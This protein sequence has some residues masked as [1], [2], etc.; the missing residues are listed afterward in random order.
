M[1]HVSFRLPEYLYYGIKDFGE[2]KGMALSESV[3]FIVSEYL[4]N[5]QDSDN[6]IFGIK[7]LEKKID[8]LKSNSSSDLDKEVKDSKIISDLARIK[9]ALVILGSDSSRTKIPLIN[10]FPEVSQS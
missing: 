2:P 9:K 5:K 8:A 3:R 6:V 4:K 1:R 10:L 7:T